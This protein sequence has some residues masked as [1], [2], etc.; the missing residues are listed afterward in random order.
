MPWPVPVD[1]LARPVPYEPMT[2]G[3]AA[4]PASVGGRYRPPSKVAP[5]W[6]RT[7]VPGGSGAVLTRP[8]VRQ[9]VD[10]VAPLAVSSPAGDTY[11]VVRQPGTAAGT[12]ALA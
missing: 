4:S 6:N 1:S 5:P 11:R 8:V 7:Q 9:A 10:G 2:T 3:W 12:G